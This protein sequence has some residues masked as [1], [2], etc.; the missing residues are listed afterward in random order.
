MLKKLIHRGQ[1][2]KYWELKKLLRD[3]GDAKICIFGTSIPGCTWVYDILKAMG[4]EADFYCDN[5]KEPGSIIRDGKQTIDLE[6][7]YSL[8][9]NVFVF[10]AATLRNQKNYSKAIGR[11]W[12]ITY[13]RIG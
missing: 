7:L 10:I 5:F 11:T 13:F 8:K 6:K 2:M 9:E 12:N 1:K 4:K 3:A